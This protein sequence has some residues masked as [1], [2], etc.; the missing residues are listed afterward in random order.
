MSRLTK[1]K[2]ILVTMFLV[3]RKY[4]WIVP[5]KLKRFFYKVVFSFIFLISKF[6]PRN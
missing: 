6:D 5:L 1:M 2:G 3:A 4:I